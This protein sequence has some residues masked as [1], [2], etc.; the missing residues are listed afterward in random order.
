MVTH[1]EEA[2]GYADRKIYLRDGRLERVDENNSK[3]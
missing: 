2:A 3:G 1:S